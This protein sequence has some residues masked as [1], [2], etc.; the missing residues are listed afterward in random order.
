MILVTGATAPI[1]RC[2]VEQLLAAGNEVRALTRNPETAT[3][4]AGA[5]IVAGDLS[6]SETL[7]CRKPVMLLP[8][9]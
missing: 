1:G 4:P 5:E 3:L 8:K 6:A 2:V 9:S 7:P